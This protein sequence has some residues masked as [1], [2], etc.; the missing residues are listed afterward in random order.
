MVDELEIAIEKYAKYVIQQARA[1]LS[2][3]KH[4]TS[5]ELYGSLKSKVTKKDS[6][7]TVEFFGADYGAF[8]DQGVHGAKSSYVEN[9]KSPFRYTTKMPPTK[10]LDKWIVKKGIAPRGKDGKFMTRQSLKFAIAKSIFKKGIRRTMF[11]TKPFEKGIQKYE[12][13]MLMALSD[14]LTNPIFD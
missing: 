2:K 10:S 3:G 11:F 4:N 14:N 6:K 8:L 7:Y 5:K 9:R 13:D 12:L 1:N